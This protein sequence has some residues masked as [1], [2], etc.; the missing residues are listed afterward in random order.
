MATPHSPS[1]FRFS[2]ADYTARD[3]L[4]A[5]RDIFGRTVVNLD[6]EPLTDDRFH[7][8]ATVCARPGLGLLFG[9]TSAV[10]LNHSSDL[11]VDDDLSFMIGPT[12]DWIARQLGRECALTSGDGVLMS[13][14]EVGSMS[15]PSDTRFI[16]FRA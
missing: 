1:T 9:E 15:L 16:T 4:A 3:S 10:H 8:D 11:V 14:A 2:T 13:N 7:C 5:W 12:G 6:I